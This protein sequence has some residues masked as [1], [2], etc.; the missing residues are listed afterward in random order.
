MHCLDQVDTKWSSVF[1]SR[2]R[3][4]MLRLI[5]ERSNANSADLFLLDSVSHLFVMG[6]LS[7]KRSHYPRSMILYSCSDAAVAKI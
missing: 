4:Q 7:L 1:L 2:R 5:L 3:L 6:F